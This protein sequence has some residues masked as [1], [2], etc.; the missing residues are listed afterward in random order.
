MKRFALITLAALVCIGVAPAA[1]A[2]DH[3]SVDIGGRGYYGGG[4]Y[5]PYY[6]PYYA[7]YAYGYG[8]PGYYAP[9]PTVIYQQPAE[10]EIITAPP[11]QPAPLAEPVPLTRQ[12]APQAVPTYIDSKGRTCRQFQSVMDGAAV[13][14]TA[15][16]QPD[17]SWRTVGE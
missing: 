4:F 3:F 16:L 15:C 12:A 13:N 6:A 9:A 2:R 10:T 8:Y 11:A 1:Q 7:P 14:G 17:G 5:N